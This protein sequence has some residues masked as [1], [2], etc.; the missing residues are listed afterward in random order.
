MKWLFVFL[1][2]L[3]GATMPLQAGVNLRL[4]QALADPVWASFISFAVGTLALL[5]YGLL[6]RPIPTQAMAASAPFWAWGGGLLGAFFVTVIILLAANLGA[7]TTMAWLLAGQFLCAL[8]LDHFGLISFDVHAISWQRVAGV[9]L[10]VLGAV[11]VN[12]Y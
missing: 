12:K 7:T 4:K 6:T 2:L 10:L 11:L 9:V 5:V 3:A 1:A 8:I